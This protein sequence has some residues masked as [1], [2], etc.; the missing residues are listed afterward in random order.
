MDYFGQRLR[1]PADLRRLDEL[2]AA[3]RA[4]LRQAGAEAA[5][6]SQWEL[7]LAEAATNAVVHGSEQD[8]R[9]E[10][11]VAWSAGDG[12]VC[13]EV[14]DSGAGLLPGQLGAGLPV[15]PL[16]TSGRGLYLIRESCDRVEEWRGPGGFR[17]MM[18]RAAP[19]IVSPG[20]SSDALLQ[21]ALAEISQC[22]E[23]LAA[24]YRLGDALIAVDR[25]GEFFQHAVGDITKVVPH[26]R[27]SLHFQSG[28]HPELL[29]EVARLPFAPR[30]GEVAGLVGS[31][32]GSGREIVWQSSREIA[33]DPVWGA[34]ECGFCVPLR[35]GGLTLGVL[36]IARK[37]R[38]YLVAAELSTVRTYADLFGIALANANNAYV[39][40]REQQAVREIE[41]AAAMQNDLL[42]LPPATALLGGRAVVR[43]RNARTVAGDYVDICPMPG[44]GLLLVMVD[45]M[46][47]GMS[48]A[49]FA[50]MVR[51]AVRMQA[52]IGQPVNRLIE[53][54]NR[55]LCR[56][57]GE[58]TLFATC[59]LVYIT[60]QRDRA[61]IVNAGHC[62]VL[63]LSSGA[64]GASR[65]IAP[66]GPPLGLYPDID[67]T[68]EEQPLAMGDQ[69]IM[70][71]D[72]LYEWET[73]GDAAGAWT[74]LADMLR[75]RRAEG[76]EILWEAI[77]Q[78]IHAASPNETEPRDDQTL[79]VWQCAI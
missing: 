47:K 59:A 40:E 78:R 30:G 77:Q 65:E 6:I 51:T 20:G 38:P 56:Q 58:L 63:W 27:L 19:G 48:A 71:T 35:A 45:V 29:A 36:A 8:S 16:Q 11:E 69:I 14:A 39:R 31:V 34:Y 50:G 72:G 13:L 23:S 24:F 7:V 42:P 75:T 73:T 17:L 12:Q 64:G 32:L 28:L 10:I 44:G 4:F 54:I 66:S 57:T 67:Y 2:R 43:R 62:P 53:E 70:V 41:L 15:D 22:Y 21:L 33:P 74:H 3:F 52:D 1:V 25:L 26:D 68:V 76:G 18:W 79:L 49:I 37:Q 60:P 9:R 46:G 5:E 55:V 61:L